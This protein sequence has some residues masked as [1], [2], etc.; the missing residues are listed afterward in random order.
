MI[1]IGKKRQ[2]KHPWAPV[3]AACKEEVTAV[4]HQAPAGPLP[5]LVFLQTLQ[6]ALHSSRELLFLEH[7]HERNKA[8]AEAL[9]LVAARC[10][11]AM[12]AGNTCRRVQEC[13]S[14]AGPSPL[15]HL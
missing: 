6:D 4:A 13:R 5:G 10:S 2:Y 11:N 3:K 9:Q 1:A 7:L 14:P 12:L 15:C 8:S